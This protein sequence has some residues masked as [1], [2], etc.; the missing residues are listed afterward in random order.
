M[1]TNPQHRWND[2]WSDFIH[3]EFQVN[4]LVLHPILHGKKL[5]TKR[6]SSGIYSTYWLIYNNMKYKESLLHP[7]RNVNFIVIFK[8]KNWVLQFQILETLLMKTKCSH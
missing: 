8:H 7:F 1:Q 3:Y 2:S 6:M 5:V 4:Y